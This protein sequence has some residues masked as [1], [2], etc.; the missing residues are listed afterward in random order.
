MSIFSTQAA[1]APDA[2]PDGFQ[3]GTGSDAE[4][5]QLALAAGAIIGTWF[6]HLPSDSFTI[7]EQFA[8]SFGMPP[9]GLR[10]GLP[11]AQVIETV[12][13]D[14]RPGLIEAINAAI[15]RGG[16]YA[17]QYRVRR[18]DDCY[19][20][21]EANGRVEFDEQGNPW[22]FPGVL[23]DI[24]HRRTI[25]AERDRA[26]A[27]LR[28]LTDSLEQ[29]VSA[30]I[31]ERERAEADLRQA[32]KMEA[33]GQLTGGLAHD[34]NNLLAGI[35][36]SLELLQA[37][38]SQGRLAELPRYIE[39]AQDA[40]RRAAS[41]TH[42]LLAFSR[43]QT[44]DP[45]P[46]DVNRLVQGLQELIN[47]SV[48][49]QIEV[50]YQ[51]DAGLWQ[52]LVDPN[53]LETALLNLCINAR[54]AMPGG[55]TLRIAGAN[56]SLEEGPALDIGL[57]AGHY[58]AL[59]VAD[60]GTGMTPDVLC[61]AFDPFYTT[62]P[63][64]QG[65]GL[66]LSMVYGFVRQSGGQVRIHSEVGQG[67]TMTLYLPRHVGV[68]PAATAADSLPPSPS[69]EGR[70][71]VLVVDDEPALRTLLTD[72]LAD[73][74][75]SV[76]QAADGATGLAILQGPMPLDLLI[77]DVGLPG[78][79][80]GRQLADAGRV[81]RPGLRTLFI[82]GYAEQAV[83]AAGSLEEGMALMTKPFELRQLAER[84]RQMVQ[85]K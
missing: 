48:G 55:G 66:G 1:S 46:T 64:G 82:T 72:S 65:T 5:V 32:Q 19:H 54:D 2:A 31:A 40:T 58:L 42:R 11:L 47:R 61:R 34:F 17:Y 9:G 39:T 36:G 60:T 25:E 35:S 83:M 62:K 50:A 85:A 8:A 27:M 28:A 18:A 79:M 57:A 68:D 59:S 73:A 45:K 74:G 30:A 10:H 12:H 80:N 7:D 81:L 14:D 67:T 69:M 33:V 56:Q 29:R 76:T 37:R 26:T 13:P 78:G 38:L 16:S 84:A 15:A 43:R 77:T 3:D 71:R 49:P 22:R 44:L 23:L 20:W 63:I 51:P 70:V 6:W 41:L 24:E 4:R 52:A 75:F 21:I 53:Q